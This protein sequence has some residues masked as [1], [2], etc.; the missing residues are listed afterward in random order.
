[1]TTTPSRSRTNWPLLTNALL[2]TFLS[3][4]AIRIFNIAMPSVASS[5]GTDIAGVSWAVLSF[6]FSNIGLSL[7]FGRIG[8]IYGHHRVY[9]TGYLVMMVASFL[10]ATSTTILQL[11]AFRMMQ[12]IGASMI[13]A[14]GRAVAASAVPEERG[15]RAQGL[16]TT[17]FHAGF[18]LG[19]SIGG[20]I[21][22]ALSWRWT[23][24]FLLPFSGLGI[25]LTLLNRRPPA[26]RARQSVDYLGASLLV[27]S[28]TLLILLLDRRLA[29][30]LS[31]RDQ[32]G[33]GM[34]LAASFVGFLFWEKR[35]PSPILNLSL[36]K[37]R[38]FTFS[39][40][41]LLTMAINY[42][43]AS[44]L[45]PFYLQDILGLTPSL[46][47]F[48]FIAAPVFT[49]ALGPLSGYLSDRIGPRLPA[50]IGAICLA[51][52]LFLGTVLEA[53]SHWSLP[54]LILAVS[55]IANGLFNP[56]NSA[57][58]LG[59]APR[60]HMGL[61]SGTLLLMFGLGNTLGISLANFLMTAAFRIHTGSS[62]AN[63]TTADPKA[64]VAALNDTF[65]ITT[66]ICFIAIILSA[67]RGER[68]P[69]PPG[70]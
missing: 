22:D 11:T 62:A 2:G 55:G 14:V 45:L 3:G 42:S 34:L 52:S 20:I 26:P 5:L 27:T 59:A 54:V 47:G 6:Q 64:F 9:L 15:G 60:Q 51:L 69:P 65:L 32:L 25:F 39:T 58:M 8:D 10:C 57:G 48:M 30:L 38:M 21:I 19:P 68:R 33:L 44:F 67:L 29:G 43:L 28:A 16:M 36:F 18:L 61:A 53:G 31:S 7:V 66:G 12:G 13:G 17:A 49:V 40:V 4:A 70:Q 50:T 63:L 23:F 24:F 37:I 41:S 56:A 35:T 46:I 1:M